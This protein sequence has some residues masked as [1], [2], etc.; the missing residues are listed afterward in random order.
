MELIGTAVTAILVLLVFY[1]AQLPAKRQDKNIQKMQ[2]EV[3][4]K[5]RIITYTGLCGTVT[6]VLDD[7]VILKTEPDGVELSIEKWA[8]AGLDERT[9]EKKEKKSKKEE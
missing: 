9:F 4:E 6:K 1:L 7:R 3:K 8:I 2:E 5:D